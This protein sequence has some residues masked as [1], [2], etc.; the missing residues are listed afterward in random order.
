MTVATT[1]SRSGP[2]AG[3]GTTGPF[4]VTFPFVD[5]SH[6]TVIRTSAAGVE[7]T[8]TYPG[9]YTVAGAGGAS[10]TV[11]LASPLPFG[12]RLTILRNVPFTQLLDYVPGDPFPAES[13]ER[14]LDLAVMRDQQLRES[15]DRTLKLPAS[16]GVVSTTLPAPQ[17]DRII[18][19]DSSASAL[20]NV[21]PTTLATIVN[22]ASWRTDVFSGD[23]TT[24]TFTLAAD[25]GNV[26]ALDVSVGGVTQTPGDDYSVSGT[27]VTFAAGAIPPAGTRNIVVRYG[28]ALPQGVTDAGA[29]NFVPSGAGAVTR[30]VQAA[31]RERVLSLTDFGADPTGSTSVTGAVTAWTAACNAQ[32]AVGYIPPG[33]Y[34]LTGD[35][36]LPKKTLCE[37][38]FTGAFTVTYQLYQQGYCQ[39]V[40]CSTLRLRGLFFCRVDDV[41]AAS[42]L[43][44]GFNNIWGIFWCSFRNWVVTSCAVDITNWSVNHNT[45]VGGRISNML[46]TGDTSIYAG[47]E[48]HANTF[49]AVDFTPGGI[50]QNDTRRQVNFIRSCYFEAGAQIQGNFHVFG[51]HGDGITPIR[52]DRLTHIIGATGV[53]SRMGRD[54]L[55]LATLN[56]ARG[57][58]WDWLDAAGKPPCL[59]VFGGSGTTVA[60]DT[61]E[62]NGIGRRY[63][64]SLSSAFSGFRIT[65]QPTGLNRF[66]LVLFYRSASDFVAIES[67]DGG[68]ITAQDAAGF[69]WVD[70]FN[71]W[72]MIRLSG[73]ASTTGTT[74][75][76]LFAYAG[77]GGAA[78]VMSIG[79]VFAGGERA[80]PAPTVND[81]YRSRQYAAGQVLDLGAV[82]MQTGTITQ[83]YVSSPPS[84]AVAVTFHEAFS[85][86]AGL[87]VTAQIESTGSPSNN[88]S[89]VLV[90]NITTSGCTLT[91][92]Y[93]T[94][95]QGVIHWSATGRR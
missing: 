39:G 67:S 53:N 45:W 92:R 80:I 29:V 12:E 60:T 33:T 84:V 70:A 50:N 1:V 68:G 85:S 25:P 30:N 87:T 44:D 19:W 18:G 74:T 16:A 40:K 14:G 75:V 77:T 59:S 73:P 78:K 76:D 23:G 13:H 28:Q 4:T 48:A 81:E 86:T 89:E 46:I 91:V 83:G 26:N 11:T 22:T 95:F 5:P 66:A 62:P 10:G 20:R 55:S 94:D 41:G 93:A 21:D 17:A 57:G 56:S 72:K 58:R 34:L 27:L 82:R 52:T 88:G 31:L 8:L 9:Q 24:A 38:T 51:H 3:A 65:L 43:L 79:G 6:L 42:V 63:E 69:V 35:V 2:Y 64:S 32:N 49:D 7:T 90:S 36:F 15:L 71:G 61:T 54:F 47:S 37:G